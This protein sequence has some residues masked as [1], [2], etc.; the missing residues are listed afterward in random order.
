MGYPVVDQSEDASGEKEAYIGECSLE[1]VRF[2]TV[3]FHLVIL[4][5]VQQHRARNT[6]RESDE[7]N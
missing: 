1:F 5:A 6:C 4:A 7:N 3:N 2:V